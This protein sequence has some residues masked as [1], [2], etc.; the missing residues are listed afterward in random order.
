[1][2]SNSLKKSLIPIFDISHIN[3]IYMTVICKYFLTCSYSSYY[4]S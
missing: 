4:I 1:M 2:E 3:S